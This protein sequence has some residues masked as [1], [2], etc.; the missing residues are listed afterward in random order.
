VVSDERPKKVR[1]GR[2]PGAR[3][4]GVKRA[5][6]NAPL[7]PKAPDGKWHVISLDQAKSLWRRGAEPEDIDV[8]E[9]HEDQ[10]VE[11]GALTLKIDDVAASEPR[12]SRPLP[13]GFFSGCDISA[14]FKDQPKREPVLSSPIRRDYPR[15]DDAGDDG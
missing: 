10:Q 3:L 11:W 14:V 1:R 8:S 13:E 12:L 6:R 4:P 9:L 2:R 15:K 5:P 7:P